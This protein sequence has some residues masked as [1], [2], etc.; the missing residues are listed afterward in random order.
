MSILFQKVIDP[1]R[2]TTYLEISNPFQQTS[3]LSWPIRK[4]IPDTGMLLCD[5]FVFTIQVQYKNLDIE[6]NETCPV[7][8]LESGKNR[9]YGYKT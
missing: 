3:S 1:C 8:K 2:N 9:S 4:V 5:H 6:S 7:I